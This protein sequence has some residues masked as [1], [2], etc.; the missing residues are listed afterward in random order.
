MLGFQ[1]IG[2]YHTH[3]DRCTWYISTS[4]VP[5]FTLRLPSQYYTRV[6]DWE[7]LRAFITRGGEGLVPRPPPVIHTGVSFGSGPETI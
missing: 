1:S 2:L 7:D 5:I 3:V 6:E 4:L